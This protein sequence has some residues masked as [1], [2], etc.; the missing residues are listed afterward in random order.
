[1]TTFVE[2]E[3]VYTLQRAARIKA[4]AKAHAC[5]SGVQEEGL[6]TIASGGVGP[7]MVGLYPVTLCRLSSWRDSGRAKCP[8]L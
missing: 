2:I 8:C 4:I 3:N 1:M 7:L 6:E 5:D